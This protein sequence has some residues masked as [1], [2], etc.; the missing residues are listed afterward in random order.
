MKKEKKAQLIEELR[1]E[2]SET[3]HIY[4]ADASRLTVAQANTLRRMCYERDIRYKVVKNTLISKALAS[5][6]KK[7]LSSLPKEA[8]KGFTA[9]FFERENANTCAKLIKL[10]RKQEEIDIPLLKAACIEEDIYSGEEQLDTLAA[11]KSRSELLAEI[12][13]LL[14]SPAQCLVATLRSSGEKL[15]GLLKALTEKSTSI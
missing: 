2:I 8:L 7:D 3:P 15:S 10:Y 13:S 12:V 11:L 9:I 4:L 6:K 14:Q 1:E 5:Q